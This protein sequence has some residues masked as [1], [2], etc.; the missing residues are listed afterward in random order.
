MAIVY[1]DEKGS[2]LTSA[3][4]DANM[5]FVMALIQALIDNPPQA[6]SIANITVIGRQMTIF[7]DD[8][9][10]LGPFT[11]PVAAFHWRGEYVA[12]TGY[13]ENDFLTSSNSIYLVLSDHISADEFDAAAED[14]DGPLY[15]HIWGPLDTTFSTIV[16]VG[17]D[18][19]EVNNTEAGSYYRCIHVDGCEVVIPTN[20]V[21]PFQTGDELHFYQAAANPVFFTASPGVLF[22][23]VDGYIFETAGRGAVVTFK[24]IGS[25]TWDVFGG[26]L[27]NVTA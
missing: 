14:T 27:E 5:R 2:N 10:E 3:E 17:T 22:N 25:N 20:S 23:P 6:N 16:T 4:Q 8:A 1:R 7:L 24:Y 11:L 12:D 9:T 21:A 26:L 13:F 19:R 18:T 15:H